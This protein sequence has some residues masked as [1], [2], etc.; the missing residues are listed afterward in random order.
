MDPDPRI[1]VVVITRDRAR[2]LL[3]TLARLDAL[4][5][6]PQVVVVD[7]GSRDGTPARVAARFPRVRVLAGDCDRGAAARTTGVLAVPAPYVAFCDDDS[8]WEPGSLARAADLLDAHPD[9]A[10]LAARV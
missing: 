2:D 7:N 4:P 5:E 8:W 6:R 9:L 10:L 3:R 1:A